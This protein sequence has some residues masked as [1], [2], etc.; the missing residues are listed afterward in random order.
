[1]DK[2]KYWMIT[3]PLNTIFSVKRLMRWKYSDKEVQ[4]ELKRFHYTIDNQKI[5]HL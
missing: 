2:D 4:D 1:V 3:N 5:A